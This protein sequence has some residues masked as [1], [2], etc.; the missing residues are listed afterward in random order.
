MNEVRMNFPLAD[1]W[2]RAHEWG[3]DNTMIRVSMLT[4][5]VEKNMTAVGW[6]LLSLF[7]AREYR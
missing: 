1:I 3:D 4:R 5:C 7:A 2:L 6:R